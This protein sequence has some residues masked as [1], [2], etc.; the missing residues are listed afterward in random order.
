[1]KKIVIFLFLIGLSLT[2]FSQVSLKFGLKGG[3]NISNVDASGFEDGVSLSNKALTAGHFGVFARIKVLGL[4]AVQPELLYS[5]QGCNYEASISSM[6]LSEETKFKLNYIQVPVMVKFYPLL[7]LNIQAGPQ[8]G[9]LTSAELGDEDIDDG[10]NKTHL[11]L[12]VG[13][14]YDLPFGLGIDARYSIGLTDIFED[15]EGANG[16]NKSNVFTVAVSYAF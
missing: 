7:G 9:F 10:I 6:G 15:F 5:M 1:M 11:A 13:A 16:S 3:M 4:L 14:G 2:S 12:N 8:I